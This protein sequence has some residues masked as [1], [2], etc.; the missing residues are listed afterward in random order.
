MTSLRSSLG[1]IRKPQWYLRW[2]I[3]VPKLSGAGCSLALL[4]V[5]DAA[6]IQ[7]D[8]QPILVGRH[9]YCGAG[10]EVDEMATRTGC[11]E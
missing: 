4:V 5:D 9:G 7:R 11:A 3:L 6:G 1:P 10:A 2:S 8:V